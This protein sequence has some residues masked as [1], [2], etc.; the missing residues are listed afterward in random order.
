VR[1]IADDQFLQSINSISEAPLET[2]YWISQ[3]VLVAIVL[4]G[5]IVAY[6]QVSAIKL[7]ELLK[8]VEQEEFRKARRVVYFEIRVAPSRENWWEDS[9]HDDW[10]N[11]A[12][13]VCAPYDILGLIIARSRLAACFSFYNGVERIF[14]R[15]WSNSIV[16]T[17]E[18][19]QTYV[20]YRRDTQP[21]AYREY[22][23]LYYRAILARCHS[24]TYFRAGLPINIL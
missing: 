11:A 18:A 10:E 24:R 4:I 2:A 20:K 9:V 15:Q 8:F 19:L 12:A 22:T 16:M 21:N 5:A 1:C 6:W 23:R 7:F 14:L 13:R 17:Y 3:I